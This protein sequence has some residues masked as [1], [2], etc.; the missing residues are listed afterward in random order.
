MKAWKITQ[1]AE[2]SLP[3]VLAVHRDA[4]TQEGSSSSDHYPGFLA[5]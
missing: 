2:L 5:G 4:H 1:H 3:S